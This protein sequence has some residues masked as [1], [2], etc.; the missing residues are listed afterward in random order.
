M[1]VSNLFGFLPCF[2]KYKDRN[3]FFFFVKV[4]GLSRLWMKKKI[5]EI[6]VLK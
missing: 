4:K 5:E 1:F 6:Y 2:H 3:N